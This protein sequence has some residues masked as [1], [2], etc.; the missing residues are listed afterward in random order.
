MVPPAPGDLLTLANPD[1]K[2]LSREVDETA[3]HVD[4]DFQSRCFPS[5]L[6]SLAQRSISASQRG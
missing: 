1:I 6:E 5:T 4:F 2:A 3:F